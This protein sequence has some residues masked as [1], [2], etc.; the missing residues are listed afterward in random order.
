MELYQSEY[1][2]FYCSRK[3]HQNLSGSKTKEGVSLTQAADHHIWQVGSAHHRPSAAQ[4][5]GRWLP[6]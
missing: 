5:H 4:P 6:R 3:Q 2:K 1:T